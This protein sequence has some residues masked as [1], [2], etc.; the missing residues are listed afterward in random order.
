MNGVVEA[1]AA[2]G[3]ASHAPAQAVVRSL[4]EV[5]V[6]DIFGIAGAARGALVNEVLAGSGTLLAV[7][8]DEEG[9]DGL[10]RDLGFFLGPA[11]V[12][13]LPADPILPYDDLSPD[14]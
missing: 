4:G 2:V 1:S 9:A 14:R 5:G 10:A 6:A 3:G 8:T 11:A 7:A 12:L 13:R